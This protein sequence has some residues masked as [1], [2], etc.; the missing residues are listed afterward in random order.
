MGLFAIFQ[1]KGE[2]PVPR[3]E[4]V[5]LGS[6]V[7]SDDD[8]AWAGELSGVKYLI[9]YDRQAKPTNELLGYARK[10]LADPGAFHSAVERAKRSATAE[11]PR[12]A[13][14]IA[15]LQVEAIHF[16]MHKGVRRILADLEGGEGDRSWRVEFKEMDCE[17]IGFD[18]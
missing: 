1:G 7:W 17:G 8:E 14:E 2:D 4:D 15:G 13:D 9:A 6:M 12:L 16:Y 18:T 5:V 10:V 11:N 3:Y